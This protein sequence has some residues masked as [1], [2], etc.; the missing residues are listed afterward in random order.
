LLEEGFGEWQDPSH[1]D[2]LAK[3]EHVAWLLRQEMPA[4][5]EAAHG[6]V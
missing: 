1:L 3:D 5:D 4:S 6:P 2:R